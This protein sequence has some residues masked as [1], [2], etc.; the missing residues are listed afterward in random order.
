MNM[1]YDSAENWYTG[2]GTPAS[3]QFDL[4]PTAAH[5]F[6]HALG[7]YHATPNIYCPGL[8]LGQFDAT[9][10]AGQGLGLTNLR[11]LES[12]DRNGVAALY[13]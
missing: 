1:K 5:E 4:R 7:L 13:P 6:G 2:S 11:T 9:M 3:N 12:D 10:C 8:G